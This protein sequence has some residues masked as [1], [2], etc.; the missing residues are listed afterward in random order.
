VAEMRHTTIK[1]SKVRFFQVLRALPSIVPAGTAATS[2]KRTSSS[3]E[4]E[5]AMHT[6]WGRSAVSSI[7]GFCRKYFRKH[8]RSAATRWPE[9]WYAK[10][11]AQ[12]LLVLE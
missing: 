8:L 1:N 12:P 11:S 4:S 5:I 10:T 9:A 7:L 2:P 6:T 3:S